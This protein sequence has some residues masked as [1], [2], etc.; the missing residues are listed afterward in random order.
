MDPTP[1]PKPLPPRSNLA[2]IL[3]GAVLALVLGLGIA[4]LLLSQGQGAKTAPA[5]SSGGLVID[6]A[7]LDD[8]ID[9]TRPL[10]CFVAGQFV[11]DLPLADCAQRNGVATGALDVGIDETGALAAAEDA[12]ALLTPLP[13]MEAEDPLLA[14]N[15]PAPAAPMAPAAPTPVVAP[16][17]ACWR[18]LDG[19]WRRLSDMPLPACVQTLF[20]GRCERPGG[21]IYGRWGQQTLR[22]VPGRVEISA[23]NTSFRAIAE[24]GPNCSVV[25]AG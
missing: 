6:Q 25:Q 3:M 1:S 22:L 19:Q 14:A 21:A 5:A 10:R 2:L 7:E 12:G 23:D 4:W 17:Q 20:S 11:G 18:H 15:K 13:P 8:R 16:G 24:Q 9:P